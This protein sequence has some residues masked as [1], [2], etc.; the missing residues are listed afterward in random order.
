MAMLVQNDPRDLDLGRLANNYMIVQSLQTALSRAETNANTIPRLV[1]RVITEGAWEE[2]FVPDTESFG[3]W[4]N[5][6][7]GKLNPADFRE[8]IRSPR[9]LGCACP[10]HIFERMIRETPAWEQYQGLLVGKPGNPT[11]H[12]QPRDGGRF[13][14]HRIRDDIPDTV[15]SDQSNP[16]ASPSTIPLPASAPRPRVRDYTR[17]VTTGTSTSYTLRRLKRHAPELA[18]KVAKGEVSPYGA[19]VD[20]GFLD[21]RVSIPIDA[22]RAAKSIVKHFPPADLDALARALGDAAGYTLVKRQEEPTR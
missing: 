20:A 8:F 17:E 15:D 12:D 19:A 3:G 9:P 14:S 1:I 10:V 4:K 21:R 6:E 22:P 2:W 5:R 7:T 13:S 11:A 18:E 16:D